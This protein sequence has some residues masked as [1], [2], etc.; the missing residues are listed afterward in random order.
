VHA[1]TKGSTSQAEEPLLL[2]DVCL[3]PS[4]EHAPS[5]AVG[6]R[7]GS[8]RMDKRSSLPG[9]NVAAGGLAIALAGVRDAYSRAVPSHTPLSPD[10]PPFP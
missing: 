10:P 5:A 3:V 1:M 8:D 6:E 4:R 2:V 9:S 7:H